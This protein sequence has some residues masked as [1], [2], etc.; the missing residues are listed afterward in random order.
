M[1]P[2]C[3]WESSVA[4]V[5]SWSMSAGTPKG[6]DA[7]ARFYGVV[8]D[9]MRRRSDEIRDSFTVESAPGSGTTVR[10]EVPDS[11]LIRED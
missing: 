3:S 7:G 5:T 10:L 4:G 11:R 1:T 9:S 2:R 6:F 8:R